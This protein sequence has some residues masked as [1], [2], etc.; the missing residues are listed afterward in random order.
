M[1]LGIIGIVLAFALLLFLTFRNVSTIISAMLS[2]VVVVIFNGLSLNSVLN[3]TYVGGIVNIITVLF[4][5]ILL[6]TILGQVYTETGAAVSIADTFIKAFVNKAQGDRKIRI[7]CG[8]IIVISC[9]FQF[10]GIDSFI[11]LFTT[12][13][14][15]VTMW[16][17]LNLPRRLIPGMLLCS[18]GVGAC[19][20]APTV[21]NVL[22]MTILGTT[23]T[24]AAIPGVIAFLIIEVGAWF[25][26]STMTIHAVHK[27]EVFDE[28]N[29]SPVPDFDADPSR[30]LPSF[31][32]ALL[33]LVLVFVL[34]TVVKLSITF[35]LASGIILA[36]ILMGKNIRL[37]DQPDANIWVRMISTVNQGAAMSTKALIEISVI[38]GLA[39][40]VSATKAFGDLANGLMGL[41]IHPYLIV[42]VSVFILV[43]LTS[44]PPAGLSIIIPIFAATLISQTGVLGIPAMPEAV[45]RICSTACLTFETLPWNGMIVVALGLANIKHKEGYLP[46]FLASVFFPVVGAIVATMLLVA[47]PGLA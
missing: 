44:S 23:S 3:E 6:G 47:F 43:A 17:R 32:I 15:V 40:V 33:P 13:P 4:M 19:A 20:G 42:L 8:V 31:I 9:L 16:R 45:H 27:N 7:A 14:I 34:F 46:M 5:M 36:L 28:G 29:M 35:A 1:A 22:P 24:A 21:H 30:K 18:T 11:V 10:G 12:F 37:N 26:I 25:M 39:A 38:G 41:P 2:V